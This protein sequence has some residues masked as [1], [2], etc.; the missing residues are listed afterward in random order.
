MRQVEN[1]R[2]QRSA[3]EVLPVA[4]RKERGGRLK[5]F[6]GAAPGVGKTF[7]LLVEAQA[8]RKE[9]VD[10]VVG[11]VETHGRTETEALITG[12]EIIPGR[13]V[14]YKGRQLTEMNLDAVL[15]RR[16]KLALVDELAHTN[17]H[18]SRHP[19]RYFD[20]IELLD[21]GIDVYSTL[22]IMHV[23]SLNDVVA[24]ITR[25]RVRDTLPDSVLERADEIK[26]VDITPEQLIDRL[27]AGKVY[28]PD[29]AA[30]RA[31]Q[32]YFS[33]GNLTALRELALRRTAQR[34]DEQLL[35]HMRAHAIRG[36]W[37]AGSRVLVCVNE[38][39]RG[40]GLVRHARRLADTL[41]AP[42]TALYVETARH[43]RLSDGDRDRIA[44]SL[45]LATHLGASA[46]TV[47]GSDVA[48]ELIAYS[49]AN[50]ITHIVIGKSH[51]S[52]WFQLLHG[53]VV[54]EL[55]RRAGTISVL[56]MSGD[57]VDEA[58]PPKAARARQGE[59]D[60]IPYLVALAAV[61]ASVAG[62]MVLHQFLNV[63]N[64]ALVFLAAIL[65]VAA[66]YGLAPSLF[67]CVAGSLAFNFFFLPPIYTFTVADPENVVALAFFLIVAV[68]VS[69]ITSRTRSEALT[70]RRRA[71]ITAEL[72]SFSQ[73]LA[74]I[75]E[76]DDLLW[77]IAH[78]VALMLNVRVVIL[79]PKGD[80][81]AVSS[82]FPPEDQLDASDLAAAKW[83]WDHDRPAGRGA[84]TLPGAPRLFLPM[85][86]SRGVVGVIGVDSD[87]PGLLFTPD[88]QR[89]LDALLDQAAVAIERVR[90]A[91]EI[92]E[93]RVL[94][95]TERLRSALLTSISHDLTTPLASILG[96]AT[97]LQRYDALYDAATRMEL[98]STISD[99]AER[100]SRFVRNLLD[101][102][103]LESGVVEP[104]REMVDIGEVVGA[105]LERCRHVLDRHRVAIEVQSNLPMVS[106]DP[107][108]FEQALF[109]LLDNAAKYAPAGSTVTIEAR[110][111]DASVRIAVR[112]E[113]PGIPPAE[114][115]RIFEKFHRAHRGDRQRAGTGLGLAVCRGFIEALGGTI[116][117][118]NRSDRPGAV[119][120]ITFPLPVAGSEPVIDVTEATA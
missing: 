28:A 41:H 46:I 65:F 74:G 54:W 98:A 15:A 73:K 117:A 106:L 48:D 56:V 50:N 78:Q 83:C 71:R 18:G 100:L 38:D 10:V 101:M 51:R 3:P 11:V 118:G 102:T 64:V 110:L 115:E 62:G 32:H 58:T 59:F 29:T 68:F 53:S 21:A 23:E 108:L 88:E 76:L 12:L 52:Q 95:E 34:V 1:A 84:A 66:R 67:A 111:G 4:T 81:V 30:K 8:R 109:N 13:A 5:I 37:A 2:D 116:S 77:A 42:W 22:N 27:H 19:K 92:D 20:V 45:R 26:L 82:G 6:L 17:A 72:F 36:P 107:V 75:V 93:T 114:L 47:P 86:T 99:E 49:E 70:A 119:F 33:P 57:D 9:G 113:G 55:I 103:K 31:I 97:S 24:R 104:N 85:R 90:L 25:I 105:A 43:H 44:A 91:K 35:T 16:P 69:N 96:S 60:L 63:A 14:D 61:G 80:G 120:I 7:E 112:D 39:P 94:A 89:L 40:Q 79:L 87:R